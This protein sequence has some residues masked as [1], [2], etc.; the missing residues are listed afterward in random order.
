MDGPLVLIDDVGALRL[1]ASEAELAEAGEDPGST[2]CVIGRHGEYFH[3]VASPEGRLGLSRQMGTV[4]YETLWD[5]LKRQREVEP[6]LHRIQR[7]FPVSGEEFLDELFEELSLE[8]PGDRRP[9]TVSSHGQVWHCEGLDGV[10]RVVT[11]R[12]GVPDGAVLVRD[13]YGHSYVARV[14]KHGTLARRLHGRPLY[15]EVV[16]QLHGRSSTA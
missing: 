15:V 10:D 2:R 4:A 1:Y 8:T 6:E 7:R 13:P 5:H 12:A 14:V 3:L 9:W 11:Q 16:P